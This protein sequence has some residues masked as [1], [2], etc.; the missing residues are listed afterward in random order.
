[1]SING[2]LEDLALAD[3][4]QFVHLSRRTGTLYLWREDERRA[5]IGFHDGRIVSA[6]SPGHRRLGDLLLAAEVV[7]EATLNAALQRQK[8]EEGER[9]LGQILLAE[10]SVT[11]EDIHRLIEEQVQATIF[12]LL[13]WRYG[14]FH[15]EVGE[16]NPIDDIGLVPG[17]LLDDLDLN[18]QMLLIEAARVFDEGDRGDEVEPSVLDRRLKLAGLS[19]TP[20]AGGPRAAESKEHRPASRSVP[21]PVRCQVVSQDRGLLTTLRQELPSDLARVVPIRPREAGNRVPGEAAPPIVA[22]QPAYISRG[23]R[24]A[25]RGTPPT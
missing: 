7:D 5:E 15:F 20:Q 16:L 8:R 11:R 21:E 1:M 24:P 3:V 9:I 12:D 19:G 17:E 18:T 4:L 22:Q 6:W 25:A 2:V 13:T 10:G 23:S 14:S